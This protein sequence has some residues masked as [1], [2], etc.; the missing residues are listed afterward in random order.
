MRTTRLRTQRVFSAIPHRLFPPNSPSPRPLPAPPAAPALCPLSPVLSALPPVSTY[1]QTAKRGRT[2]NLEIQRQLSQWRLACSLAHRTLAQPQSSFLADVQRRYYANSV[3]RI[4]A[5]TI[6]LLARLGH[7]AAAK[8][9]DRAFFTSRR[10]SEWTLLPPTPHG[11]IMDEP[12]AKS[13]LRPDQY[14]LGDGLGLSRSH[15]RL[16]WMQSLSLRVEEGVYRNPGEEF[17]NLLHAFY[18]S[19]QLGRDGKRG[20]DA[21]TVAFLIRKLT[22][23]QDLG[24]QRGWT[25]REG[26]FERG[27]VERMLDLL[28]SSNVGQSTVVIRAD[29]EAILQRQTNDP[30]LLQDEE[31]DR[32]RIGIQS[33]V[34]Q[35]AREESASEQDELDLPQA[36]QIVRE[37]QFVYNTHSFCPR[38]LPPPRSSSS[39]MLSDKAHTLHLAAQYFVLSAHRSDTAAQRSQ[40]LTS[41]GS[42]YLAIL[43]ILPSITAQ[44]EDG[45]I[46]GEIRERALSTLYRMLWASIGVW[47]TD[48]AEGLRRKKKNDF[49]MEEEGVMDLSAIEG[50]LKLLDSTLDIFSSLP[51][52][53]P[54]ATA[55]SPRLLSISPSYIRTLL[56]TLSLPSSPSRQTSSP[57]TP[58]HRTPWP[59]LRRSLSTILELRSHDVRVG[60]PNTMR[61]GAKMQYI[62]KRRAVVIAVVRATILAGHAGRVGHDAQGTTE[63]EEIESVENRLRFLLRWFDSFDA[64]CAEK[65]DREYVE[66]AVGIV[67]A[68]EWKG[69]AWKGW[70]HDLREVVYRWRAG[71]SE[72]EEEEVEGEEHLHGEE[73]ERKEVA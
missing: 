54:P 51:L 23:V 39:T 59:I 40:F 25:R 53:S 2:A 58:A 10:A 41:A 56:L 12:E 60:N 48:R 13:Y 36:Q 73:S 3:V 31:A 1:A 65:I 71:I 17:S 11:G 62:F 46:L 70:K 19:S 63:E 49:A 30:Y 26:G 20:V 6:R 42:A 52:P 61:S 22:E 67:L 21:M 14:E 38:P 35:L 55:S 16:A 45:M 24:E 7:Y 37:M 44:Q 47:E 5:N 50:S 66:I 64:Q 34:N 33:L 27:Q 69:T 8:E 4:V 9:L 29:L 43:Q 32:L 28:R 57:I 72:E 18:A 15:I 68:E